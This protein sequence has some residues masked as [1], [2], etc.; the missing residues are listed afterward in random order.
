MASA[1]LQMNASGSVVKHLVIPLEAVKTFPHPG[2]FGA[3]VLGWTE[4][5][6][7]SLLLR[8]IALSSVYYFKEEVVPTQ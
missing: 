3:R 1:G 6:G 4:H 2:A 8:V 5:A 7:N